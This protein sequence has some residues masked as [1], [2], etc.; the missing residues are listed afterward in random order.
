VSTTIAIAHHAGGVGKTTTALNLAYSLA[1]ARQKV[2]LCDLDPQADLTKRLGI[3]PAR[4]TLA[5]ALLHRLRLKEVGVTWE[6]AA[7]DVIP[8]NLETM[9]GM[10]L[11]LVSAQKREERLTWALETV[12]P[13]NFVSRYD[14]ILLDCP[15]ALSLLTTNALY[16]ADRVLIPVQAQDKAVRQLAPLLQSIEE[17]QGYRRGAPRILG[18]LLTMADRTNQSAQAERD[19]RD[20]YSAW[21]FDT[22]IPRRTALADDSRYEAPTGVYAPDNPAVQAYHALAQEVMNRV[23]V[24]A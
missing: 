11:A 5:P 16:A 8:S 18:M 24:Y 17:V 7:L 22:V 12:D 10:D 1:A 13:D 6:R 2:L 19:L 15:P 14:F 21:V 4:S 23:E 3:D 20:A 9:A